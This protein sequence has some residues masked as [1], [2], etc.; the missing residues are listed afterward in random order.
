VSSLMAIAVIRR[1]LLQLGVAEDEDP[2]RLLGE[3]IEVWV[4]RP[5]AEFDG[6]TPAQTLAAPGGEAVVRS[7][8]KRG[9]R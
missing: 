7:W 6:R 4:V 2:R 3:P 8:L 5:M 1:L 9:L